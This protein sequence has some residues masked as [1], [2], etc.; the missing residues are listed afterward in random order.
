MRVSVEKTGAIGRRMTVAVPAAEVEAQVGERLRKLARSARLPG[1]RPGKAP[2][3]VIEARYGGQV[4]QEVAGSLIES[5][6]YD[7]LGEQG[8]QPAAGPEVEPRSIGRGKDLEYVAVFDVYPK[9]EKLDLSGEEIEYPE[10]GITDADIDVTVESMRKQRVTWNSVERGAQPGDRVVIDF[11]GRIE[12]ELFRGG[13]AQGHEVI[14]GAGNL[15]PE[16]EAGLDGARSGDQRTVLIRFP[17]EYRDTDVAGKQAEFAITVQEVAEPELPDVND[18]FAESFGIKEGGM[19]RLREDVRQN[20]ER[21]AEDRMRT[22][23]RDQVLKA[24]ISAND[25]E[26]PGKLVEHEIDRIIENGRAAVANQGAL[27]KQVDDLDRSVFAEDARRRVALG[28]I[29]GEIVKQ[30]DITPD[31]DRVRARVESMATGYDDQQAFVQ[32]YYSDRR[33]LE[34]LEALVVEEQVIEELVKTATISKKS[35]SLDELTQRG[36]TAPESV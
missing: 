16:F 4:M 32:W 36:D 25:I 2:L 28:L 26:L 34:Q 31:K 22:R 33:R 35:V 11:A 6:L 30:R 14:L 20:L 1:F 17:A 19:E 9:I 24:L 29:L 21:E 13:E 12:G 8:L 18:E 3:K 15:L 27:S 10:C 23:V 5:S 7:A